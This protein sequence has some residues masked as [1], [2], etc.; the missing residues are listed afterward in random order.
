MN[1]LYIFFS[2]VWQAQLFMSKSELS[3]MTT[4]IADVIFMLFNICT[5][6]FELVL[7]LYMMGET[8]I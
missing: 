6:A 3:I 4:S 7:V 8:C 5:R 2:I 1:G